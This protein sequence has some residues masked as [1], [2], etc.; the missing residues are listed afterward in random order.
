MEHSSGISKRK[1]SWSR[2]DKKKEGDVNGQ[3]MLRIELQVER[4]RSRIHPCKLSL[5]VVMRSSVIEL[6]QD[7]NIIRRYLPS[8]RAHHQLDK[9]QEEVASIIQKFKRLYTYYGFVCGAPGI[10]L[11]KAKVVLRCVK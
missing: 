1:R 11:H 9:F 2:R 8:P 6:G 4:N 10:N 3:K 5:P 7:R